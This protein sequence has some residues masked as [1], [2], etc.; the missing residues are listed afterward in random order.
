MKAV[1]PLYGDPPFAFAAVNRRTN[2]EPKP[3]TIRP[4]AIPFNMLVAS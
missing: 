3:M 4:V 1:I 2:P